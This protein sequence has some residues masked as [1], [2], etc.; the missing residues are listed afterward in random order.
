MHSTNLHV[1]ALS[2]LLRRVA[3]KVEVL[4]RR[5]V[6]RMRQSLTRGSDRPA[7]LFLV[8]CQRS[9]TNMLMDVLEQ[10]PNTWTYN[11]DHP[12]AFDNYRLKPREPR[13]RLLRAARCRWVVFKPLC[14]SQHID[15]LLAEHPDGKAIWP[16]RRYQD[17]ANSA[18]KNFGEDHQLW[19]VRMAATSPQWDHWLVDRMPAERRELVR[20]LYDA[21]MSRHTAAALKWYLRNAIY[22]D[23]GLEEQPDRVLLICY[24]DLVRQPAEQFRAVFDFLDLSFDPACVS[25]V[26]ST[27][28]HKQDFPPIDPRVEALC[29]EMTERL[30]GVVRNHRKAGTP[31]ALPRSIQQVHR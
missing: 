14:D 2:G 4:T 3:G 18:L 24:E 26:F 22:F 1:P 21:G 31:A 16:F 7:P 13:M 19:M 17:V 23:F 30:Q 12:K 20:R 29:E 25:D 8:G 27:S 11:E 10:D 15:R 28:V 9:G 6:K 5:G